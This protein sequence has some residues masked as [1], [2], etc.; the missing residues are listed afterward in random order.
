M[1]RQKKIILL[2][3]SLA[4]GGAEGVC[5]NLANNLYK[6]GWN[7]TLLLMRSDGR[8][9][10]SRV[11]KNIKIDSLNVCSARLAIRP[12]IKY[13]K[14]EKIKV[15]ISFTYELTILAII[16]RYFSKRH[17]KLVARNIN[18]LSMISKK[19]TSKYR[20]YFLYPVI[21]W[22]Y[23]KADIIVNQCL[24]M[25]KEINSILPKTIGKT[26]TIYNPVSKAIEEY[27]NKNQINNSKDDYILCVGRLE[28]QKAFDLAIDA[29]FLFQQD[30]P[31]FKLKIVG[32]GRLESQ[33]KLKVEKLMISHKVIFCG[34]QSD[35]ID[36]YSHAKVTLLT[37]L[38]EGF[39]NVLIESISLGTPIVSVD[40]KNGPNEIINNLNGVLVNDR[41]DI[42]IKKGLEYV[43]IND[44][45][46]KA[47]ANQAK[48]FS[49]KN[50]IEKWEEILS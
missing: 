38:F 18:S 30:H 41:S 5:V 50:A 22:I 9:L 17:F 37:S 28:N 49:N 29:F 26:V 3:D 48:V 4:S 31:Q 24:E 36:L 35:L 39:P 20:K 21:K 33:L 1:P 7:V 45:Q 23:P 15:L 8:E 42:E 44:Y 16:S 27:V 6:N 19:T 14:V 47:I 10:I 13:L 12:L 2:I 32:K 46:Y 25:E 34:Y 40:C 11:D 43:I